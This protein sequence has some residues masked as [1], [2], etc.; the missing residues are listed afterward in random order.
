MEIGKQTECDGLCPRAHN[1]TCGPVIVNAA[2]FF[3]D[4]CHSKPANVN[5]FVVHAIQVDLVTRVV[6]IEAKL[7]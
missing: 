4:D 7:G 5:W 2:P 3:I 1:G 6:F